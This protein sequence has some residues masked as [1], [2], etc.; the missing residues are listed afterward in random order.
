MSDPCRLKVDGN[1]VVIDEEV[2]NE[3]SYYFKRRSFFGRVVGGVRDDCGGRWIRGRR[4]TTILIR[5]SENLLDPPLSYVYD[6]IHSAER[7]SRNKPV[8]DKKE[9]RVVFLWIR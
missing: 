8:S 9:G 6:E 4:M 3:P 5:C 2:R 7:N 1:G